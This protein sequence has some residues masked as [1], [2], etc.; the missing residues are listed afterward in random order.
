MIYVLYFYNHWLT[1]YINTEI[2]TV[3][4]NLLLNILPS[5]D[6]KRTNHSS[7]DLP[8]QDALNGGGLKVLGAINSEQLSK[9]STI[10]I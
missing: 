5:S 1:K 8:R 9:T 6:C 3:L 7:L 2:N 4:F 10:H